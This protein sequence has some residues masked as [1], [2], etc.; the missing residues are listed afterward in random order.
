MWTSK[1]FAHVLKN[2]AFIFN[3]RTREQRYLD[4]FYETEIYKARSILSVDELSY[5]RSF[6]VNIQA[7]YNE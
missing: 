2:H 3:L 7:G 4:R 5:T 6:F 1:R